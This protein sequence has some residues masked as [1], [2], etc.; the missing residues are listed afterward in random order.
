MDENEIDSR[1]SIFIDK[2]P[3]SLNRVVTSMIN[4]RRKRLTKTIL[5]AV[6]VALC[7]VSR[8]RTAEIHGFVKSCSKLVIWWVI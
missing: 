4:S 1:D 7:A 2:T 3:A 8:S 6:A 5:W